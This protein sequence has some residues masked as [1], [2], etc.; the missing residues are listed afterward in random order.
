MCII[1]ANLGRSGVRM[2]RPLC[3]VL[4][5]FALVS[6]RSEAQERYPQSFE[7][8]V[9]STSG[10]DTTIVSLLQQSHDLNRQLPVP[11]RLNML[12]RQAQ[13]VSKFR[14]D[15]GREWAN[16]LFTLSFQVKEGY[17]AVA[18]NAAM[19]VLLRLDP[20]RALELLHSMSMEEPEANWS[21]TPPKLEMAQQVFQVLVERDGERVLP[22]LEQEAE[23][24]GKEGHYPY[25]ALGFAAD[26]ASAK[27]WGKNNQR[28]IQLLESV[29]EPA[30]ARYSQNAHGYFD[31]FQFGSMLEVFAGGLPFDSVQPALRLLV[32]NL[33]ATDTRK[34]QFAVEAYTTDG[35]RAIVGNVI[36][37]TILVF[38]MLINRDPELA[39]ELESTRPGLQTTLEN[40]KEGRQGV[41][42]GGRPE[43]LQSEDPVT[44][45]RMDAIGLSRSN[46]EAAIAEA[47]QLPDD[48][49]ASTMLEV[50]R[51]M[52]GD[53]PERTAELIAETQRKNPPTDDE[54]HFN[55]ISAQ[56]SVMAAQNK[57]DEL[58]ELL[59]R[60]F[61]SASRILLEQ[62]SSGDIHFF[63]RLGLMVQIGIL[64]DPELT[65]TFIESLSPSYVKAEALLIAAS[66]L[67]MG[68]R[69]P[70]R[71]KIG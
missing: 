51:G 21:T 57:K 27:Y 9:L 12:P 71:T 62:Q 28:A 48:K 55:L 30:F 36:D 41:I 1:R 31:D 54:M 22:L 67:N 53:H 68:R 29:F 20:D 46:P 65:I 49:R 61:A 26:R 44:Q 11:M 43:D 24:M 52:A 2:R 42:V 5:L 37:A 19:V 17:R 58:H 33:L 70:L 8:G 35:K 59:Q 50:A 10:A 14:A 13:M 23:I 45:M 32:K 47:E 25:A 69:V 66:A 63:P 6:T 56:A 40:T 15:L 16:E 7:S 18:Q 3:A 60:G 34:Y 38:G 4:A 39:R 64:N